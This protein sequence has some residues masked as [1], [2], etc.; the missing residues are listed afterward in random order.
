MGHNEDYV[1]EEKLPLKIHDTLRL[2]IEYEDGYVF[3]RL[4]IHITA[5]QQKA[6]LPRSFICR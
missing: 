4:I 6:K 5:L 2:D 3:V 1:F